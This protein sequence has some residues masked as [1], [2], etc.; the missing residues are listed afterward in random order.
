MHYNAAHA[1]AT[2]CMWASMQIWH[3]ENGVT[4][5]VRAGGSHSCWLYNYCHCSPYLLAGHTEGGRLTGKIG[6]GFPPLLPLPLFTRP[7][8]FCPNHFS[9][10][11]LH[12]LL[13]SH[14]CPMFSGICDF[15]SN[16][17]Y[18]QLDDQ[19]GA[20]CNGHLLAHPDHQAGVGSVLVRGQAHHHRPGQQA[21]CQAHKLPHLDLCSFGVR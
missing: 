7:A 18:L 10:R 13:L 8:P 12:A 20:V 2:P 5:L 1:T 19:L 6:I 14:N 3:V 21:H 9:G 4:D 17:I 16:P 15:L 11:S